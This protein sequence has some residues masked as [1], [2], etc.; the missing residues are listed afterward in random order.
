MTDEEILQ[1]LECET[2]IKWAENWPQ[3]DGS[4]ELFVNRHE[5]LLLMHQARLQGAAEQREFDALILEE[6]ARRLTIGQHP[7]GGRSE[8]MRQAR[9]AQLLASAEA[10]RSQGEGKGE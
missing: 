9:I 4:H 5:V 10:I 1:K 8:D 2:G 3:S 6:S 7:T